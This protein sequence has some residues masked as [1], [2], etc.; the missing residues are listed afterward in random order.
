MEGW[1]GTLDGRPTENT[2]RRWANFGRSGAKLIWR[3]EAVA[4]CHAGRANPNQLTIEPH[5]LSGLDQLRRTLLQAHAENFVSVNDL[6]IGLQLTHS[7][8]FAR[9]NEKTRLEPMILYHHPLLEEI[10]KTDPGLLVM[11]DGEID[12]VIEDF[13]RL[14]SYYK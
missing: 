6:L 9:P 2:L 3:G 5:T 13:I 12:G 14:D 10:Y 7:G 4:V 8:R 1:D 11:T